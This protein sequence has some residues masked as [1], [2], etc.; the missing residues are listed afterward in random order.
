MLFFTQMPTVV[1]P[2]HD[3]R[4]VFVGAFFKRIQNATDHVVGKR[5][6]SEI[7][8]NRGLP[9]VVFLN[10]C[11]VSVGTSFFARLRQVF[12]IIFFV[13]GRKLYFFKRKLIEVL[14]RNKPRFVRPI[15][16]TRQK[17]R[18]VVFFRKL[19]THPL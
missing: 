10:V 18:L 14:L 16:S 15:D 7:P 13:T 2:K 3:N 19:L 17:E 8:L 9:L 6:R 4:V 11:K 5:D 12:Q 1:A